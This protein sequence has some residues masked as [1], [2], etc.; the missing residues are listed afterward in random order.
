MPACARC[1]PLLPGVVAMA[2]VVVFSYMAHMAVLACVLFLGGLW[3]AS[4]MVSGPLSANT[5]QVGYSVMAVLAV[6]GFSDRFGR[7]PAST[8]TMMRVSSNSCSMSSEIFS[9]AAAWS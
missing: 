5:Y 3:F 6:R 1:Y 2:I 4:R 8:N 7:T 9:S